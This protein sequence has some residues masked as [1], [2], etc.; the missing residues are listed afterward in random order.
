M[1]KIYFIIMILFTF[2]IASCDKMEEPYTSAIPAKE[3]NGKKV[4]L[5]DYTGHKC[6][7]CPSAAVIAKDIKDLYKDKVII[8]AVHA[9]FYA[10]PSPP[11]FPEDFRTTTGDDW[12]TFFGFLTYPNGMINRKG[13]P[14]KHIA[15]S[16]DWAG[17]VGKALAEVPEIELK[18][19]KTYTVADTNVTGK[20]TA[21]FLKSIKKKL[22]LQILITE[23][24]IIAPQ[25]DGAN[26][27]PNYIH[28]HMLRASV[29]GD[30][31]SSLTNGNSYN[32]I[33]SELSQDFQFSLKATSSWKYNVKQC[34]IIAFVYDDNTKEILQSEEI[35]IE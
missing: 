9:G 15:S 21:K 28:R 30:W 25:I 35:H 12:N 19:A 31:G 24:S 13:F 8:L 6:T 7:Y 1:K 29:N 23:D 3:W 16:G 33:D 22:R 4:L 2:I 17:N 20:V 14:G 5:E 34:S 10:K 11:I 18:I 27:I 32:L 26:T